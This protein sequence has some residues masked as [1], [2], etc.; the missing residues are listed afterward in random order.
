MGGEDKL[1][2]GIQAAYHADELLLPFDVQG[3]FRLV[4]EEYAVVIVTH[5][6]GQQDD[7]HP[8]LARRQFVGQQA[9]AVLIENDVVAFA[10]YRLMGIAE[11]ARQSYPGTS[12]WGGKGREPGCAAL[13]HR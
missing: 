11:K 10:V 5:Q 1:H 8:L 2:I 12:A 9:L 4:H 3:G 6:H 13:R 7:Q